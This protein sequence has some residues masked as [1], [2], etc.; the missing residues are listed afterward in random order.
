MGLFSLLGKAAVTIATNLD[1]VDTIKDVVD[2]LPDKM[3]KATEVLGKAVSFVDNKIQTS[4]DKKELDEKM[5][6]GFE[7]ENS[8]KILQEELFSIEQSI[9]VIY[10]DLFPLSDEFYVAKVEGKYGII[11]LDNNVIVPFEYDNIKESNNSVELI[12][13]A[14]NEKYGFIN[15]HNEIIIDFTFVDVGSFSCGLAPVAIDYG[16]WG[17]IDNSGEFV[18]EPIYDTADTFKS[19]GLA[20][21]SKKPTLKPSFNPNVGV[22][23]SKGNII[24]M[25]V[26]SQVSIYK[27]HILCTT[28]DS[29]SGKISD[30]S[31]DLNGNP[32]EEFIDENIGSKNDYINMLSPADKIYLYNNSKIKYGWYEKLENEK[33]C[34]IKPIYDAFLY[35]KFDKQNG[36]ASIVKCSGLY[37]AIKIKV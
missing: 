31:F 16:C 26:F 2:N 17:Y 6:R 29:V 28:Y 36:G 1:K 10:T 12:P 20:Q 14:K 4:K 3:E 25:P 32:V 21:I 33:I 37:G 22:I 8:I 9:P 5:Q 13:A 34:R 18:I 7:N 30:T 35:T 23:N 24:A 19:N 27:N 15:I 11:D